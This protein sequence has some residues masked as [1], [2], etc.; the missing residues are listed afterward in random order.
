MAPR[1][2]AGLGLATLLVAGC[3]DPEDEPVDQV[4]D[5]GRTCSV[6]RA[7]VNTL[8]AEE[9]R[10]S[11]RASQGVYVAALE[12]T[13][14]V[15]VDY[16][17]DVLR[18]GTDGRFLGRFG[19]AGQGPGEWSDPARVTSD[20]TDSL[21]VSNL[22]GRAVVF[23]SD[24]RAARTVSDPELLPIDGFTSTNR[25]YSLVFQP[26]P[27]VRSRGSLFARVMDREGN[28]LFAVGPGAQESG[29]GGPAVPMLVAPP[30][31]AVGDTVFAATGPDVWLARW[32]TTG[33]DT[34]VTGE[35]VR[36]SVHQSGMFE[37]VRAPEVEP[38]GLTPSEEG[39]FWIAGA[40]RRL[41]R[42]REESLREEERIARGL[43]P[44]TLEMARSIDI[45]N[46]VFDG[47]LLHV[48]REGEVTTAL[49]F[50]PVPLGFVSGSPHHFTVTSTDS[51]LLKVLIWRSDLQCDE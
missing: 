39:G 43:P 2:W 6:D 42:E 3:M 36:A 23:S 18:Y 44:G 48:T 25:P 35:M 12:G 9:D 11:V 4:P 30:T 37:G 51:G 40:I 14:W 46:Q 17:S 45:R 27:Q 16:P 34:L 19:E 7:L 33:E 41:P 49:A 13:G 32:T 15:V 28:V 38:T 31:A 8:G 10:V 26:S 21:W 22:R 50:D 1:V 5:T 24:G 20:E 29:D 47:M